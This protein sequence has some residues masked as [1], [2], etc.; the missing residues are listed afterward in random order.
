MEII[1][2]FS[3]LSYGVDDVKQWALLHYT[4]YA[5]RCGIKVTVKN[6]T[7]VLHPF[8]N[9]QYD[10]RNS[11]G[12]F[13]GQARL[14]FKH[15]SMEAHYDLKEKVLFE[16]D[17]KQPGFL[18]DS[19]K[20]WLNGYT[21]CNVV[22]ENL[23]SLRGIIE[24]Q[25][26]LNNSNIAH[27]SGIFVINKRDSPILR[28]YE[29]E[30]PFPAI[31]KILCHP[32][33]VRPKR[34]PLSFYTSALWSDIPIPVPEAWKWAN[35]IDFNGGGYLLDKCF[36]SNGILTLNEYESKI[37][38]AIFR[39]TATGGGIDFDNQR[40]HLASLGDFGGLLDA[41]ITAWNKRDRVINGIIDFQIPPNFKL[42]DIKSPKEQSL[43]KYIICVDGHQASSRIV[44]YLASGCTIIM[45]DSGKYTLASEMWIHKH[46][47]E[48]IH[49]IRVK[50]DL[51]DL[52]HVLDTIRYGNTAFNIAKNAYA[53]ANEYLNPKALSQATF[54]A[55]FASERS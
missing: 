6:S 15:G 20:W 42:K 23:W 34:S 8:V 2:S 50:S 1:T 7:V 11:W 54:D 37:S 5:H 49:Y 36:K 39:G 43:Y 45:V 25:Q 12:D 33:H 32:M 51:S 21:L 9:T 27:M 35:T 28:K 13:K 31:G 41:G 46:M 4:F 52:S 53:L 26:M 18:Q 14:K 29:F 24:L 48:N 30:H 3:Q 55:I 17:L 22:P 40:L 38:K 19:N 16:N 44:W 47:K 10:N